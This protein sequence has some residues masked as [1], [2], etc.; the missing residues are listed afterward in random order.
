MTETQVFY[1][2]IEPFHVSYTPTTEGRFLVRY[3]I[4]TKFE[5]N[6]WEVSDD[7]GWQWEIDAVREGDGLALIR[8]QVYQDLN[9]DGAYLPPEP[10]IGGVRVLLAQGDVV[11]A[12]AVTGADGK[13]ELRV[14]A[15]N[16]QARIGYA[17]Y[18][19]RVPGARNI[20][21]DE[22]QVLANMDWPLEMWYCYV[23]L[24]LAQQRP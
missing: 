1:T 15:G 17:P 5:V 3:I 7:G 11:V 8:G 14:P 4:Y 22:G 24:S 2:G 12:E 10:L 13:Y 23:P 6:E 19:Y 9:H 16:Y 20:T 21:C 18:G